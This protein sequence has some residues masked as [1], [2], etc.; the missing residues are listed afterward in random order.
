MR[1]VG[2]EVIVRSPTCSESRIS[3]NISS[4]LAARRELDNGTGGP[5]LAWPGLF[6]S[7]T[8]LYRSYTTSRD[9]R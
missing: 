1:V 6:N 3:P 4:T 5:G 8:Q 2:G 7:G 9:A